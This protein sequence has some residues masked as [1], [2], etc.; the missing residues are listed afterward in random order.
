M[1]CILLT[2]IPTLSYL[3]PTPIKPLLFLTSLFLTF[4][5]FCFV[6]WPIE[7]VQAFCVTVG[8]ELSFG[9]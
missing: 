9:A 3:P 7:F 2:L 4:M 8:L 5:S 1:Q 6:L